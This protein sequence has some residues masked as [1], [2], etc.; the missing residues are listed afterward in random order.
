MGRRRSPSSIRLEAVVRAIDDM[1]DLDLYADWNPAL[2]A[3]LLRKRPD[4]F[5]LNWGSETVLILEFIRAFDSRADWQVLVDQHKTEQYTLLQNRLQ[6]IGWLHC[7]A[8]VC[9]A[10]KWCND[11]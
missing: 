11:A 7:H 3:G 2:A 10:A 8:A 6:A 5:A 4:G 9:K 1:S